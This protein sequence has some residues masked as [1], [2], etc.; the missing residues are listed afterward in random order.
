MQTQHSFLLLKLHVLLQGIFTFTKLIFYGNLR[1]EQVS[2]MYVLICVYIYIYI[3]IYTEAALY[4]FEP[5]EK[6]SL[7]Y[8]GFI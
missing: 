2:Y 4:K 1:T 3:Y 8:N 7:N 6:S 5:R